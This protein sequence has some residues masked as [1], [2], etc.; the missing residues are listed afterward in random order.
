M[1]IRAYSEGMAE[2][3]VFDFINQRV[4]IRDVNGQTHEAPPVVELIATSSAP[5]AH[6]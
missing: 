5:A 6:E 3:I 2:M 4:C 1:K